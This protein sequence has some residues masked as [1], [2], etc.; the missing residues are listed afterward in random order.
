[1]YNGIFFLIIDHGEKNVCRIYSEFS[2]LHSEHEKISEN[3]QLIA[4]IP[5]KFATHWSQCAQLKVF[6]SIS[7]T[8]HVSNQSSFRIIHLTKNDLLIE[9]LKWIST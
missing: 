2:A 7:Y 6:G 5:N 4:R 3:S 1:M 9:L 8:E